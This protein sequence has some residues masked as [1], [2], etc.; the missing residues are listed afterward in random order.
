MKCSS[1]AKKRTTQHIT[2]NNPCRQQVKATQQT[3]NNHLK[4]MDTKK[5]HLSILNIW[6]KYICLTNLLS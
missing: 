2:H 6:L 3:H 5:I 1:K 4:T